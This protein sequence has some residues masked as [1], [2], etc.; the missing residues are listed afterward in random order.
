MKATGIVRRVDELGRI[1]IPKEIRRTLR[2]KEGS[3]LEIFT[4][5]E[6]EIVLKKYSRVKELNSFSSEACDAI[7]EV[8][9]K[10]VLLTDKDYVIASSGSFKNDY[11]KKQISKDL[12][13]LIENRK[14]TLLNKKDNAVISK[15]IKDDMNEYISQV[16][17]PINAGGD[18]VGA[19]IIFVKDSNDNLTLNEVKIASSMA[20]F[21][22]KQME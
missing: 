3:P 11:I 2:M 19:I 4:N 21:L 1:V 14:A 13:K 7:F 18:T 16:I 15:L 8:I 12:E 22:A 9:E 5:N 20:N 17:V 6:G 10:N